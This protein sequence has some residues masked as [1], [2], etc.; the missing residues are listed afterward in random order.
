[1]SS[2]QTLPNLDVC[3]IIG[4]IFS[5][6]SCV[7]LLHYIINSTDYEAGI[8]MAVSQ[9]ESQSAHVQSLGRPFFM[10]RSKHYD[11]QVENCI[12]KKP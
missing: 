8:P 5:I 7:I 9:F 10:L 6:Y 3:V 11:E 12:S 1:M 2:F 4:L